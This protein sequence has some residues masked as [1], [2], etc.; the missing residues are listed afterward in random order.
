MYFQRQRPRASVP[1]V[2]GGRGPDP[3]GR[4]AHGTPGQAGGA[5]RFLKAGHDQPGERRQGHQEGQDVDDIRQG[6]C[7]LHFLTLVHSNSTKSNDY[8]VKGSPTRQ[9]TEEISSI[10]QTGLWNNHIQS[11]RFRLEDDRGIFMFHVRM[12]VGIFR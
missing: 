4:A 3:S 6:I 9:E 12:N 2:G 8:Q 10:W 11:E 5:H 1:A 7:V